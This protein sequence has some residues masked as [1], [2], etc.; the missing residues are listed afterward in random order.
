[1]VV[2]TMIRIN[3]KIVSVDM[4]GILY[5]AFEITNQQHC[6]HL[7]WHTMAT[8]HIF[9]FRLESKR[10]PLCECFPFLIMNVLKLQEMLE[11]FN[12]ILIEKSHVPA[13]SFPCTNVR[14]GSHIAVPSFVGKNKTKNLARNKTILCQQWKR[15]C[16]VNCSKHSS[17]K[18]A[19]NLLKK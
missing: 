7:L 9:G 3:L 6:L 1:M 15:F 17:A 8:I 14:F 12:E 16:R 11:K 4:R 13:T 19:H 18:Y 2:G 5:C 10:Q